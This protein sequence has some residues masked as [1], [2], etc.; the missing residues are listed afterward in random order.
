MAG[1]CHWGGMWTVKAIEDVHPRDSKTRKL[2]PNASTAP[3][4]TTKSIVG[5]FLSPYNQNSLWSQVN[6]VLPVCGPSTTEAKVGRSWVQGQPGL[7][8]QDSVSKQTKFGL[9]KDRIHEARHE[10]PTSHPDLSHHAPWCP[11]YTLV[12]DSTQWICAI[13][14]CQ[15]KSQREETLNGRGDPRSYPQS[16]QW[17]VKRPQW[18]TFI[19]TSVFSCVSCEGVFGPAELAYGSGWHSRCNEH[20]CMV[21]MLE[22]LC[23]TR[24][25]ASESWDIW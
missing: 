25:F 6:D 7:S 22:T 19:W 14:M 21:L 24:V 23:G 2:S 15:I 12:S 16:S 18:A 17:W 5:I 20:S 9:N 1:L 10:R 8:F 4:F 3:F 13:T 11:I